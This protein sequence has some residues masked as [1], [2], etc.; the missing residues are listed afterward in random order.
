MNHLQEFHW[1]P[2]LPY[3]VLAA[4]GLLV[5]L[6]D[7]FVR[8]LR[9]DH[10]AALNILVFIA[11][12]SVLLKMQPGTH[13]LMGG[14][15][16]V[17]MYTRYFDVILLGAGLIGTVYASAVYSQDG[18]YRPEFYPL[19][20]FAVLGMMIQVAASDLLALFLGLE[21]TNL[22]VYAL[23]PGRREQ[24]R[25]PEAALKFF[26]LGGFASA[27]LLMGMALL[28]GH[29]GGTG[30]AALASAQS[31]GLKPGPLPVVGLGLMLAGFAFK[32]VLV[33]LHLWA[34]DVR[35]G[36]PAHL[37]G[38]MV[39]AV[40]AAVLAA[41][42]RFT[43][44]LLPGFAA[45][46]SWAIA[47]LAAL[48]MT[49]GN[50]LALAQSSI[51]RRLA[52]CGMAHAGY[53]MLGIL[54]V[55]EAGVRDGEAAVAA[56]GG[57]LFH[58]LGLSLMLLAAFGVV[59]SLA[60]PGAIEAH[61]I[62]HWRGLGR[63]QPFAATI[64]AVA[65]FSLAGVPGTAGFMGKFYIV[66]AALG[67]GLLPLAVLGVANWL[68]SVYG[69]LRVVVLMFRRGSE[70]DPSEGR[71]WESTMIAAGLAFLVVLLGILPSLAQRP[72]LQAFASLL[73]GSP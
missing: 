52:C 36:A 38:F 24:R 47:V 66:E 8:T 7:S 68:L 40:Q 54:A 69:H 32:M 17:Q 5:M 46:L 1:T 9:K 6:V 49:A 27:F 62:D 60:R 26:L 20:I 22:A 3:L 43:L 15:L 48:S 25:G 65:M 73:N 71:N 35:D 44:Q 58:L 34:P 63:R 2:L 55:V 33:P 42:V 53:L 18:Q 4:G 11:A 12:G 23:A 30:Y 51:K 29:A 39:A 45:F 59:V 21:I 28:Y 64:M 70:V 14:L 72:A 31:P 41:L 61:R 67:A 50:L 57:V 37:T 19:V 13:P 10:L 56:G 16:T